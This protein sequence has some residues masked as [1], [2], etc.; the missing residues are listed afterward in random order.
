MDWDIRSVNESD[1]PFIYST[2]INAMRYDSPLGKTCRVT[3]FT[4]EYVKVIDSILDLDTTNILI[5]CHVEDPYI[6]FGYLVY[7]PNLIH[8]TYVKD[9]FRQMGIC[10]SLAEVAKITPSAVFTNKTMSIT[11]ILNKYLYLEYNPFILF[12]K[13]N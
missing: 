6:I 10:K 11:P 5:A 9:I 3:I 7:Q 4:K 12:K 2:W 13:E 8:F 1:L